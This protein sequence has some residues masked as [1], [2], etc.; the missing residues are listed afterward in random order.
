MIKVQKLNK[1]FIFVNPDHI[2][3]I[4][5]TPD[6]VLTFNERESM[7]VRDTPEEIINKILEYRR[8]YFHIPEVTKSRDG[9]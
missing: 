3:F 5:A 8:M 9:N 6:T 7:L 2:R 4:E 1:G